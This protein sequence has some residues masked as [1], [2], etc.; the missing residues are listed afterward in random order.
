M[1]VTS[2]CSVYEIRAWLS[3]AVSG[4]PGGND[5]IAKAV[6]QYKV[7]SSSAADETKPDVWGHCRVP[8]STWQLR[9]K[10][11]LWEADNCSEHD[12]AMQRL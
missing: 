9:R 6:L 3:I 7:C 5:E 2:Q 8:K 4:V 10:M 12:M 11:K 1:L